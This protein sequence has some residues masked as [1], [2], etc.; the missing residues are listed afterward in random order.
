[1]VWLGLPLA[2]VGHPALDDD[3]ACGIEGLGAF[4][5]TQVQPAGAVGALQHCAICHLRRASSGAGP[6]VPIEASGPAGW[7]NAS[8]PE[9]TQHAASTLLDRQ[10]ARA[11]PTSL[12]S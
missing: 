6:A 2:G 10:P 5:A 8:P 12:P 3:T 9:A 4:R 1:M 11:P 7:T